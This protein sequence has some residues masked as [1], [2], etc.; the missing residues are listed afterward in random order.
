MWKICH[1]KK[2][3]TFY[4]LSLLFPYISVDIRLV[5]GSSHNQGRLEIKLGNTWGTICDDDWGLDD[6][7]VVC[8]MLGYSG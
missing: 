7:R 8:R 6:A 3:Y 4:T 5:G 2:K 1:L